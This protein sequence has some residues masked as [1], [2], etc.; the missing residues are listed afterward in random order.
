M[1]YAN[2]LTSLWLTK[3]TI[4]ALST[5]Q[6]SY[7]MLQRDFRSV[8][9]N[10]IQKSRSKIL[11]VIDDKCL[12]RKYKKKNNDV[13]VSPEESILQEQFPHLHNSKNIHNTSHFKEICMSC[14]TRAGY[15]H[16]FKGLLYKQNDYCVIIVK[17]ICIYRSM[18]ENMVITLV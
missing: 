14:I 6:R 11:P 3:P 2:C 16:C 12:R 8:R 17:F 5:F 7:N 1:K 4:L 15:N 9:I 13:E 18:M 10:Y